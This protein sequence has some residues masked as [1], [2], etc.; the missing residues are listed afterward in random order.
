VCLIITLVLILE[1]L[2]NKVCCKRLASYNSLPCYN[3]FYISAGTRETAFLSALICAGISREVA[4]KCKEQ[5]LQS[6]AC[7]FTDEIPEEAKEATTVIP[8][9]GDNCKY[10]AGVAEEFATSCGQADDSCTGL[11]AKHNCKAGIE[12]R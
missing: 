3:I 2:L 6:C 9:C 8:G 10:G 4:R 5:T 7:D 12:V 11:I 1:S